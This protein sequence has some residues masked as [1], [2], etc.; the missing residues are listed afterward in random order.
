MRE[1]AAAV[2]VKCPGWLCEVAPQDAWQGLVDR[3]VAAY[4]RVMDTLRDRVGK[5]I[6]RIETRQDGRQI[7]RD[8]YGRRLAEYYPR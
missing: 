2:R 7:L 1:S 4:G 5:V 6:G 3:S 8:K